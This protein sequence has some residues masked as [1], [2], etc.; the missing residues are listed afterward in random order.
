MTISI[1]SNYMATELLIDCLKGLHT[2]RYI[3]IYDKVSKEIKL[4]EAYRNDMI[5]RGPTVYLHKRPIA[6]IAANLFVT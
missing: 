6:N 2:R 3:I 5:I 4:T 1:I